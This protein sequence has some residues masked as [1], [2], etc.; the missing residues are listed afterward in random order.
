MGVEEDPEDYKMH[1][2]KAF[3]GKHLFLPLWRAPRAAE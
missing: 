3:W 2:F 1:K